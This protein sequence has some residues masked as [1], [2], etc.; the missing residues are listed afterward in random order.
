MAYHDKTALYG[1]LLHHV[2][3]IRRRLTSIRDPISASLYCAGLWGG[4]GD[5]HLGQL[6][7][8][9]RL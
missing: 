7:L 8:Q 6:G 3:K 1:A 4:G 9:D 2:P 5:G